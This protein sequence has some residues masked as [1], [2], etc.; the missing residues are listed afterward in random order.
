MVS[1]WRTYAR[2]ILDWKRSKQQADKQ[3]VQESSPAPAEGNTEGLLDKL[4]YCRQT[5][6][7]VKQ[8]KDV[9]DIA[10]TW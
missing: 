7:E 4:A 10:S 2:R 6:M 8:V 1:R 9:S 3:E 5:S